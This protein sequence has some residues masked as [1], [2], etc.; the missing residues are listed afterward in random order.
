[1]SNQNKSRI[2]QYGNGEYCYGAV[3]FGYKKGKKKNK[4]FLCVNRRYVPG[5]DCE[6]IRV[7]EQTV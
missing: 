3:A 4:D 7:R 5:S 1:M 6:Q 2:R